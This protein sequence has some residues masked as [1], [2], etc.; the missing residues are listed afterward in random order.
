M[1]Q[2]KQHSPTCQQTDFLSPQPPLD[3]PLVMVLPT[4]EPRPSSTREGPGIHLPPRPVAPPQPPLSP[5]PAPSPRPTHPVAP[6]HTPRRPP[7][8]C[9]PALI[10]TPPYR[11]ALPS[12][13]TITPPTIPP[14]PR[15]TLPSRLRRSE[16][17][18]AGGPLVTSGHL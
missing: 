4:M 8:P 6:P 16:F 9:R 1:P 11:P 17:P 10:H 15:P 14:R 7:R 5:H 18:S 13:P 3:T 12:P 2:A